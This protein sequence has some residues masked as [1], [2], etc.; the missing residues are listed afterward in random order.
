MDA[1]AASARTFARQTLEAPTNGEAPA[2]G[3]GGGKCQPPIG[4]RVRLVH[5]HEFVG[6]DDGGIASAAG[7]LRAKFLIWHC[8]S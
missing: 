1:L 7:G 8:K 4:I 3:G 6:A 2:Y 5:R